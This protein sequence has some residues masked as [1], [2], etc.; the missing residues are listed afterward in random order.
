LLDP[1]YWRERLAKMESVQRGLLLLP[2]ADLS[3]P[4]IEVVEWRLRAHDGLRLWGLRGTSPFHPVPSGAL[5][6]EVPTTELPEIA[7]DSVAEGRVDFVFQVPAGR[8]LED[9]VLDLLRVYQVAV[10]SGVDP[11]RIQLVPHSEEKHPD[12]FLIASGLVKRGL[13]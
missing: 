10:H 11:A 2:R 13:C 12:E 4:L 7:V 3:S 6:R 9:R 5:I 1:R 8:R